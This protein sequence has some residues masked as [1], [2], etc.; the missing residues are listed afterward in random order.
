M[1]GAPQ[2]EDL[3]IMQ[4]QRRNRRYGPV[5]YTAWVVITVAIAT[6]TGFSVWSS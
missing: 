2:K 1:M 6:L 3:S 5:T 4:L